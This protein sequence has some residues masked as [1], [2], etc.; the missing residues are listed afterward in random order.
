MNRQ[1]KH[2]WLLHKEGEFKRVGHTCLADFTRDVNDGLLSKILF[3]GN[4]F[5]TI[6]EYIDDLDNWGTG[7]SGYLDAKAYLS[8][9]VAY[10]DKYGFI[11]SADGGA[12]WRDA[13]KHYYCR[14]DNPLE[15]TDSHKETADAVINWAMSLKDDSMYL[16]NVRVAL[17]SPSISEAEC[18][19]VASAA[20]VWKKEMTRKEE[21]SELNKYPPYNIGDTVEST[22]IKSRVNSYPSEYGLMFVYIFRDEE[23]HVYVWKTQSSFEENQARC[24][25]RVKKF[26]EYN[27][28]RQ[29][30]ITHV[31][32]IL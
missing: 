28:K 15:I 10:I 25:F 32:V 24:R 11:P 4:L 26:N 19:L 5:H 27:G 17:S 12:T 20:H 31:K 30:I 3:R 13:A 7:G 1:R 22:L 6:S 14:C 8:I 29:T 2:V 21:S 18:G 16:H 9:C 23:G